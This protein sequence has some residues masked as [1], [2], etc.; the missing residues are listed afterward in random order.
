MF[1]EVC[2]GEAS[3]GELVGIDRECRKNR[4]V[5]GEGCDGH[6]P[7]AA[8]ETDVECHGRALE[9]GDTKG[10]FFTARY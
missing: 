5:S 7:L 9:A 2:G 6:V 1:F 3:N 8:A 10:A 4:E